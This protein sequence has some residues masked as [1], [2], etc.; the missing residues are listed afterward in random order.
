[1]AYSHPI[2]KSLRLLA[3][4]VE[5]GALT[6]EQ[7]SRATGVH[8]SQVS[9]ILAGKAKRSSPNVLRLE[10]FF[11]AHSG[12]PKPPNERLAGAFS[13]V[14]DGSLEHEEALLA[15]AASLQRLLVLA[16]RTA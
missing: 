15:L 11:A 5:E 13:A 3:K 14:W 16:R 6:Q 7:I 2:P 1:M 4:A 10:R 12:R 9:R 8:Q